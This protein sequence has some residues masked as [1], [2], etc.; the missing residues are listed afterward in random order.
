MESD[1]AE[2]ESEEAKK[3]AVYI[4]AMLAIDDMKK[5]WIINFIKTGGF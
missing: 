3:E 5:N 4:E 2:K 1:D